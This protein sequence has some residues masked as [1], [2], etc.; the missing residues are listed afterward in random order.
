MNSLMR[1][2]SNIAQ[3]FY[4]PLQRAGSTCYQLAY[5]I[6]LWFQG[7]TDSQIDKAIS[8][9][10]EK[11]EKDE[12]SSLSE[13]SLKTLQTNYPKFKEL[14]SD[15]STHASTDQETS[16]ES[17][18]D[19]NCWE[20]LQR[21]IDWIRFQA[22]P[23]VKNCDREIIEKIKNK[24][25][26]KFGL[27][28]ISQILDELDSFE[29]SKEEFHSFRV[30]KSFD[31]K[32]TF[33]QNIESRARKYKNKDSSEYSDIDPHKFRK[34]T[35]NEKSDP[36]D[37]DIQKNTNLPLHICHLI[38]DSKI[39]TPV[40]T[41]I[42]DQINE[43]VRKNN[44]N[45]IVVSNQESLVKLTLESDPENNKIKIVVDLTM[46]SLHLE[47]INPE[48]GS[49]DFIKKIGT[50]SAQF[51]YEFLIN[52]EEELKIQSFHLK[53]I[54]FYKNKNLLSRSF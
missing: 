54:E 9:A 21:K 39:H 13:K 44:P 32:N 40:E 28:N 27:Q 18:S 24:I 52:D 10:F 50:A 35:I 7:L 19:S 12:S 5:K 11:K 33:D 1:I 30:E 47:K 45:L 53:N 29:L 41:N 38:L 46:D 51:E 4:S 8:K 17:S 31:G 48:D 2:A 34:I 3:S 16:S 49:R 14:L 43:L 42:L 26:A 25:E 20:E 36:T 22:F 37:I 6:N 15:E 23:N